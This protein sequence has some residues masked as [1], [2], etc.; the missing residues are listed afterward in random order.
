VTISTSGAYNN[1]KLDGNFCNF[2]ADRADVDLAA[3]VA[4]PGKPSATERSPKWPPPMAPPAA[5]ADVQGHTSIRYDTDLGKFRAYLQGAALYQTNSTQDL[6]TYNN[7]LLGNTSGF[8]TFDFSG[9]IK[10]DNWTLDLFIQNAFD[11]VVR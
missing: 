7:S 6:N 8:V 3:P 9:G 4:P 10:K 11:G 5:S 1:A 2:F